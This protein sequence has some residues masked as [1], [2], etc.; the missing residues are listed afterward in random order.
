[1]EIAYLITIQGK[2][3]KSNVFPDFMHNN[4][5]KNEQRFEKCFI[6][7]TG[8]RNRIDPFFKKNQ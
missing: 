7:E 4:F 8:V 1:M 3:E 2:P 6:S 5:E